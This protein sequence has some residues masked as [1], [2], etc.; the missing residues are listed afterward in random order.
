[1]LSLGAD[2]QANQAEFQR[3]M[4]SLRGVHSDLLRLCEQQSHALD[5]R[6]PV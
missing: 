6:D 2:I 1:M 3:Q 4:Q 5:V